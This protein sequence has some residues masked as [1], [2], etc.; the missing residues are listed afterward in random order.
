MLHSV[1]SFSTDV[2]EIRIRPIFKG[3]Y[4]SKRRCETYLRC[5]TQK[6]AEFRQTAAK[7]YGL[8]QHCMRLPFGTLTT[9]NA[10]TLEKDMRNFQEPAINITIFQVTPHSLV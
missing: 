4:V 6:R 7:A 2:S 10:T 1:G 3:Q 9:V 8:T 5:V